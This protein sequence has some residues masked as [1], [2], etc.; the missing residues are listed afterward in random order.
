MSVYGYETIGKAN[1]LLK[2]K[3]NKPIYIMVTGI[4]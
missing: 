4:K 2:V 3:Q 1:L